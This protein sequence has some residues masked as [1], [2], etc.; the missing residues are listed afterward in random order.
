M[1]SLPSTSGVA[2]SSSSESGAPTDQ[3]WRKC[4]NACA[5][6]IL[7]EIGFQAATP[8]AL[9]SLTE[10]MQAFLCEL[11]RSTRAY[12]EL[13]CRNQ[14]LPADVLLAAVNMGFS[15]KGLREYAFRQG[16]KTQPPPAAGAAPRPPAILRTGDRK[17][18]AKTSGLL[19]DGMQVDAP[20]SHSYVR[21]PT[22]KQPV[23][24]YEGVREKAAGQKRDVERAL[25]RFVAKTGGTHS[26]FSGGGANPFP[27]ISCNR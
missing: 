22:H 14:P 12:T 6:A 8:A 4:L 2:A 5:A 10:A 11:G 1:A 26:L 13:A 19:P 27:L 15:S 17:R 25:T 9:E 7:S 18:P 24:D 23:T 20:D 16:R 3:A 21:T